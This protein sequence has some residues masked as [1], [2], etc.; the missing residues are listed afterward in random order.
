MMSCSALTFSITA[1]S[2][3]VTASS[4]S[5]MSRTSRRL[6]RSTP[7]GMGVASSAIDETITGSA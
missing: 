1:S 3:R 7:N 2:R 5:V 4:A 6:R